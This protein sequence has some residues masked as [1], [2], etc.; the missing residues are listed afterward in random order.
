MQP[1][2]AASAPAGAESQPSRPPAMTTVPAPV[3]KSLIRSTAVAASR[4]MSHSL[5][6]DAK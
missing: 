2:E 3:F 5:F 6:K 1:N 4:M